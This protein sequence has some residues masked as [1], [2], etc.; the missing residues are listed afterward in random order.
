MPPATVGSS[1]IGFD[2]STTIPYGYPNRYSLYIRTKDAVMPLVERE[3][4]DNILNHRVKKSKN[5]MSDAQFRLFD[6]QQDDRDNYVKEGNIFLFFAENK[7]I[8]KGI[9]TRVE[10]DSNNYANVFGNGM[11]QRLVERTTDRVTYQYTN[12]PTNKIISDLNDAT[13]NISLPDATYPLISFRAENE[14]R[15][16]GIANIA[17]EM[18]YDWQVI[19]GDNPYTEDILLFKSSIGNSNVYTF[20]ISG[21]SQNLEIS[22]TQKDMEQ[23]TNDAVCLGYGDG[24][25][26]LRTNNFHATT[27]RTT[28]NESAGFLNT[29][30][31]TIV[32]ANSSGFPAPSGSFWIGAEKVSYTG[33]DAA[34]TFTGCTRW[35]AGS[36]AGVTDTNE[37]YQHNNGVEVYDAQYTPTAPQAGSSIKTN[38][39]KQQIIS[40]RT[41]IDRDALDRVAQNIIADKLNPITRIITKPSE[42]FE[43]LNYINIGD[44]V[45]VNDA[46]ANLSTTY[47]IVSYESSFDESSGEN[48][49]L[50]LSNTPFAFVED[51]VENVKQVTRKLDVY[52]Q[53][54]TVIDTVSGEDNLENIGAGGGDAGSK[55][56]ALELFFPIPS[57]AIAVN[58]IKLSFRNE[59][60]K[61]WNSVT[62][63][64]AAASSSAAAASSAAV[65][66]DTQG[67]LTGANALNDT[68]WK[69]IASMSIGVVN[70]GPAVATFHLNAKT[71]YIADS[72]EI[73]LRAKVGSGGSFNYYPVNSAAAT[74]NYNIVLVDNIANS[75]VSDEEFVV[76]ASGSFLIPENLNG[77]T[78]TIE[79]R[80]NT[81]VDCPTVWSYGASFIAEAQHTHTTT[82]SHTNAYDLDTGSYTTTS[83]S[84][85]TTDDASVASPTWNDRTAS[86]TIA[87]TDGSVNTDFDLTSFFTGT[88]WKGIRLA[89]NGNS[90]IKAYITSQ[91]FIK[92]N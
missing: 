28:L 85:Y 86:F 11:E 13:I 12:Q 53:G 47:E 40:D 72:S 69:T 73:R 37:R 75:L 2:F 20:N 25:N 58:S 56:E 79:G 44:T 78:I 92:S 29:T 54:S 83:I 3:Y 55:P 46:E 21:A 91:V 90:R 66:G 76:S 22:N 67:E 87:A 41:I 26:Q 27:V 64:E 6:I 81:T 15:L 42:T 52:M 7:L 14:S 9:I 36:L 62:S 74:T 59:K 19:Q 16:K 48:L 80:L 39:R 84:L 51:F 24:I 49:V 33:N 31:T 89:A 30:A 18:N 17:K 43:V 23:M 68:D 34:T 50:E 5:R 82:H 35:A 60:P 57:S 65:V 71:S 77:K 4:T 38:G 32:V 88:G 45:T 10:Y 61:T 70:T 63:S 8:L 1:D